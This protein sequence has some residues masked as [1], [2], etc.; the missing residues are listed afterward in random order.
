MRRFVPVVTALA[1]TSAL[2]P[3]YALMDSDDEDLKEARRAQVERRCMDT[4]KRLVA[5]AL[6]ADPARNRKLTLEWE[7]DGV[8]YFYVK[9]AYKGKFGKEGL[10]HARVAQTDINLPVNECV[11]K[12]ASASQRAD[13]DAEVVSSTVLESLGDDHTLVR[14]KGVS[15]YVLPARDYVVWN[16]KTTGAIAGLRDF[17]SAAVVSVD[18]SNEVPTYWSSVRG[19]TNTVVVFEPRGAKTRATYIAELSYGGWITS[20]LVDFFAGR[21]MRSLSNL[22]KELE[23]DGAD[24]ETADMSIDEIA[25]RRIARRMQK[26]QTRSS[27]LSEEVP[28]GKEELE[29]TLAVLEKK[30]VDIRA[31]EKKDGLDMRELKRRVHDDIL[32]VKVRLR[33]VE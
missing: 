14:L 23:G 31:T 16:W 2:L 13:W 18:A 11:E 6:P 20:I 26:E 27:K 21:Y 7:E 22:K 19:M 4:A 9:R 17:S 29:A 25:R 15:G 10:S 32:Q 28:M 1:A 5:N 33:A 24:E 8:Q 12:W 3:R 30:L